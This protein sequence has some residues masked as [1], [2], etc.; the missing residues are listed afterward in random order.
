MR[1]LIVTGLVLAA[2]AAG[3]AFAVSGAQAPPGGDTITITIDSAGKVV[4]VVGKAK[5]LAPTQTPP[6]TVN[7]KIRPLSLVVFFNN[8]P[9]CV[10]V[11]NLNEWHC[12]E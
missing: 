10:F 7:V 9:G 12:P 4:S 2:L 6:A 8:P 3:L 1:R 5:Y 11:P